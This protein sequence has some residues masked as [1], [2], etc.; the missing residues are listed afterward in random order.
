MENPECRS[1]IERGFHNPCAAM[2]AEIDGQWID[3][4]GNAIVDD[5]LFVVELAA[6][7]P[8]FS[9]PRVLGEGERELCL[10]SRYCFRSA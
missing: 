10:I 6:N 1:Q 7:A 8:H 4:N 9:P 5:R 3:K 2:N